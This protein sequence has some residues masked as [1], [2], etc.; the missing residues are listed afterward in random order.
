MND[1]IIEMDKKEDIGIPAHLR[2]LIN[3]TPSGFAKLLAAWDGL[4]TE[5]QILLMSEIKRCN[6]P[7]YLM[8]RLRKVALKNSNP[9]IRYLKDKIQII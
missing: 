6:P 4:S 7:N 5:S 2:E 9:F 3:P 8:E 1:R